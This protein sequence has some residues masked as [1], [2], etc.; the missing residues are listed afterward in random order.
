MRLEKVGKFVN[1]P[2]DCLRRSV[3]G[4]I[5]RTAYLRASVRRRAR[6]EKRPGWGAIL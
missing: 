4:G 2:F 3:N 5:G 1:R 6:K